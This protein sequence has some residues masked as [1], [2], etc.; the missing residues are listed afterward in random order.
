MKLEKIECDFT[1]CQIKS[2]K[3]VDFTRE[4]VFLS[5]TTDEISLVCESDFIP[6]DVVAC[7]HGWKALRISGTLE[8]GMLGVI[9]KISDILA[10]ADI[11]IFV[12]STYNTDYILIKTDNYEKGILALRR[13]GY[14]VE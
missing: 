2:I 7:E 5:K 3:N 10:E 1:V 9:A 11:S 6:S 14:V 4:Y 8:F 13:N 12:V